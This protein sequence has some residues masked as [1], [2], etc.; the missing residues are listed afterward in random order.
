M[1]VSSQIAGQPN[2]LIERL[3]IV[4][5]ISIWSALGGRW[6]VGGTIKSLVRLE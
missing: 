6:R 2:S 5:Q 3:D 4:D 1:S